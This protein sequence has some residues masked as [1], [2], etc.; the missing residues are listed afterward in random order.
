MSRREW[1]AVVSAGAVLVRPAFA[2]SPAMHILGLRMDGDFLRLMPLH[3]NFLSGKPL[4]RLKEGASIAF[5]GQVSITTSEGANANIVGRSVARFALS[6]DIWEEKFSV[7][8][9]GAD[10]RKTVSHLTAAA[11]EAWCIENLGIDRNQV[12]GD[13][14]FF[15]Q[16]DLRAE[17]PRD[18]N[19]VIGDPGINITRLI[20]VFSR[21]PRG[22]QPRWLAAG[23]PFTVAELKKSEAKAGHV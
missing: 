20:E 3:L 18:Q 6:Y 14:P 7:T 5:L 13:R 21:Q 10:S 12:P 15:V 11:T 23:G 4:E 16:L 19:G 1:L 8:R 17:D 9:I 22:T 2:V